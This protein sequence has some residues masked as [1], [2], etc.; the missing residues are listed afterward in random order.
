MNLGSNPITRIFAIVMLLSGCASAPQHLTEQSK[1]GIK[2]IAIV[3]LVP[4]SVNF[5]KIGI[6][7]SSDI[8]TQFD[9][10][11]KVT[12]SILY[13]SRA[14]I[15]KSYPGWTLKSVEYDRSALLAKLNTASGFDSAHAKEAFADLARNND[16][17]AIF[18]VRAAADKKDNNQQNYQE[19]YLREGMNVLLKDNNLGGDAKLVFRA[20]LSV[21]IVG[22]NGEVMAVGS[23]P[24]QLDHAK[25]LDPDDYGVSLD[26]KH[27]S[28]IETQD[29]LGR[30]VIVDLARRLNLCFDSLG[31]TNGSNPELQHVDVIP[32]PDAVI[33]PK[34]K[35]PVQAGSPPNS[36]DQCFSRCRQYTDRTKEQCFDAC[37]K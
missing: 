34:E 9:M 3:S 18:V 11:S 13:V 23:I 32:Q 26:M 25:E 12:D 21:A 31:F 8:Y 37:N 29:K 7:S 6:F 5:E 17:D 24:A 19:N 15:A 4:E 28:R 30:G 1:S 10:G 33:E 20:N 27:N 35:S 36:F 2:N 16:L 22:K 14:R